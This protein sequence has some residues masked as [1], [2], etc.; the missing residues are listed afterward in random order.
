MDGVAGVAAAEV[1]AEALTTAKA[2]PTTSCASLRRRP[3]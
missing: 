3:R 1:V 2:A